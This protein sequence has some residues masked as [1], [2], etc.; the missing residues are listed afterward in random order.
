M[1]LADKAFF[2][3]TNDEGEY[4]IHIVLLNYAYEMIASNS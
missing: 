1:E 4:S 2:N 3:W